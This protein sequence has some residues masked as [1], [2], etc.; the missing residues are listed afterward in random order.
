MV[1]NHLYTT[2]DEPPRNGQHGEWI[3]WCACLQWMGELRKFGISKRN[4]TKKQTQHAFNKE[5]QGNYLSA[6]MFD[7][8]F[9]CCPY[10][11]LDNK[12]P[13]MV[14]YQM[15]H[16]KHCGYICS[17]N[18]M[19]YPTNGPLT[20]PCIVPHSSCNR[21][22]VYTSRVVCWYCYGSYRGEL[23]F[24]YLTKSPTWWS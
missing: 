6:N 22:Y 11:P 10:G 3:C 12:F 2:W 23:L 16:Q 4:P 9:W 24:G 7:C 21:R 1:I 17:L 20:P 19:T 13:Y 18:P 14:P 8:L 15:L 5:M